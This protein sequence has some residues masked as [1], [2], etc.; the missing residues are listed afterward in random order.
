MMMMNMMMMMVTITLLCVEKSLRT[1]SM[2]VAQGEGGD[3][4][5]K[6]D[7]IKNS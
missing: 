2:T 4:I 6:T 5:N 7:A 3:E 1:T